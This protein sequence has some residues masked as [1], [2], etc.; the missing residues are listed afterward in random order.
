MS[1]QICQAP[2]RRLWPPVSNVP[3]FE[4]LRRGDWI[5]LHRCLS[6][7]ALW[8]EVPHEPYGAYKYYALWPYDENDWQTV[9]SM[10]D[11]ATLHHWHQ[12]QINRLAVRLTGEDWKA[13]EYHKA[14]SGGLEP[15]NNHEPFT[16]PD[17][18]RIL[19]RHS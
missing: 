5:A 14:R 17:I 15:F 10:D 7:S 2:G 13:V 9:Y 12:D 4:E 3:Q 18:E 19:N 11:G 6:C 8:V 16:A 1:C